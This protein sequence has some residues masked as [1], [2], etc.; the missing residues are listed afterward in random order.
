MGRGGTGWGTEAVHS[1]TEQPASSALMSLPESQPHV[2]GAFFMPSLPHRRV[3]HPGH[4]SLA[5][6]HSRPVHSASASCAHPS[7]NPTH[8][9]L[10]LHHATLQQQPRLFDLPPLS[11]RPALASCTCTPPLRALQPLL[12]PRPSQKPQLD[13]A[14]LRASERPG[15]ASPVRSVLSGG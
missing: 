13:F 4:L 7:A 8:V 5:T 2:P 10:L 9:A 12:V 14:R 3:T 15:R 6:P 11:A 1:S